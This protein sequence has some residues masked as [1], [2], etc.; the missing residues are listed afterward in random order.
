MMMI[1]MTTTTMMMLQTGSA[2]TDGAEGGDLWL[3]NE[4][5]KKLLSVI[6]ILD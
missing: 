2:C 1:T 6:N 5:V 4:H 3:T